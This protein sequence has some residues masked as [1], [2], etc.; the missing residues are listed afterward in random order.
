LDAALEEGCTFW[1]SADIYGDNE[2]LI[3]K[4]CVLFLI[5]GHLF[6]TPEYVKA[7]AEKS[8]KR[9]GIETIDLYYLHVRCWL[10]F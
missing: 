8:L 1:D 4:W 6:G 3:G 5:P 9:L 10:S 2:D 7:A